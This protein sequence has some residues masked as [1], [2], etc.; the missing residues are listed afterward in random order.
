MHDFLRMSGPRLKRRIINKR[1]G[2]VRIANR[3][4][5]KLRAKK[6]PIKIFP[7]PHRGKVLDWKATCHVCGHRGEQVDVYACEIHGVCTPTLKAKSADH[8]VTIKF[9]KTCEIFRANE[10]GLAQP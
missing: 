1:T 10:A 3:R 6:E 2:E 7:C 8:P 4:Q 5:F 9:C